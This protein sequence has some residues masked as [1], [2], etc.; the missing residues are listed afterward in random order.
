MTRAEHYT[1]AEVA[2]ICSVHVD[3][4]YRTRLKRQARDGL[5]APF[6][7]TPMLF[8][9]GSIDFWRTRHHAARIGVLTPANDIDAPLQPVTDDEHRARLH[10]AYGVR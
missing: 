1:A 9:K 7:L 5:P 10:Q 8:D 2:A 6:Q 4:F 3:T